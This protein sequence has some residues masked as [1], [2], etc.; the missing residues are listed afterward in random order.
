MAS[1][2]SH[3]LS[4]LLVPLGGT[5]C[6]PSCPGSWKEVPGVA[7]S[8]ERSSITRLAKPA[9]QLCWRRP[10]WN[11]QTHFHCRLAFPALCTDSVTLS[12]SLAL[13]NLCFL[14]FWMSALV[15]KHW[16]GV[17]K[18]LPH[19]RKFINVSS[20]SSHLCCAQG[21]ELTLSDQK[22]QISCHLLNTY[23]A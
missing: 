10:V 11:C 2:R 1:A 15:S 8:R 6:F 5:H 3:H 23:L 19:S 9:S 20:L 18:H 4:E 16:S 21:N 7:T 12:K 22:N 13:S 17:W 14:L